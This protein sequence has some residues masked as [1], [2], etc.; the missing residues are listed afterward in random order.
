MRTPSRPRVTLDGNEAVASIAYQLSEIIAIYPI[1]PS[2]PMGELADQ[3]AAEGRPNIWG[4]VPTVIEMQSE[5]GAAGA[6]H[7]ALQAG[8]LATTF[9]SSQGL[10][11][12]IP[13]MYK[14]AGELTATVFHVAARSL[15]THALSIFGDHSD[16][17]AARATGFALLASGSVQEAMDLALIAH[18]ATLESRIPFLHFFDGFRTSHEVMKVEMLAP[19]DLRALIDDEL[20]RAHRARALSPDRPFIRGTAQNPDVYF[21]SREAVNPFYRACPMIVEQVM[22]RFARQVGR[23]YRLFDYVGAPDADRVLVL[24]GSGAEAAHETV[25]E[26]LAR[27]EAVGL[28]K[29]RLYRPFSVAHFIAAVPPTVR[30]LAVLD[31][32]KE[33]GSIG[34][35][36][37]LD[38]VAAVHE[39]M[40]DGMA[41]FTARPRI[42]GG[43][44][45]LSSKEFT[46]AMIKAIFDEMKREH[47]KNHFTIGIHD[48]VTHT[49]LTDDPT[50]STEDPQTVRAIFYGL[51]ADGTVSANRNSIKI[52]GELTDYYAQGYFVYDS[53]KAGSMTI[54]HLRF[55]PRPI[56]SSYLITRANF[57]ACH[58]F[59]FLERINVLKVAEPGATFLLNSPYGPEEVWDHLPRTIQREILEKNI[60]FFVVDAYRVAREVGLGGR[61]NTIMQACFFALITGDVPNA[62]SR[63][64]ERG[65]YLKGVL[66]F[67]HALAAMREAMW[68]TYG[69]R[70]A[71]IVEKNL[72]AVDRA[73]EN[74]YEVRV[75]GRVTSAFDLRPPV[76]P[77][78][79]AFVRE[80]TARMIAGEGDDLP[81]SA[82]PPDGTY[83]SGT[84][85][86]EKR[87]I[88]SEIPVWD[89][90]LCIQCGKCV[91]VCPHSV[92]RAK[93][94]DP[95]RLVEAPPTF[96][97]APARWVEFK[98]W[99]YTLQ[100]APED[101]TGC[102]LCVEV[103]PAKSKTE[104]R[105]KALT[106]RPQAPLRETERANWEF[107]LRL[108]D[109][110][111]H[112]L[113]IGQ[114]KDVQLLEPLFEF[115]GACAGC[116]ETPYIK[117]LT[118]LFGDRLLIANATGCSSIYGGN[119][120]TTPYT[121][122]REG[123]G[124]AWSNS[125]FE[126]NAEFGLGLRLALN[127]QA[128]YA[129]SLLRRLAAHLG[130]ELVDAV[131]TADQ[132]T[133][134]GIR[135]QRER[136]GVLK[137]R[138]RALS[139]PE[140]R[141]LLDVADA[142]VRKSVWIIGGDGWAYDI[143]SGGV[144]HVLASGHDVNILVLDTEVYSN[145]GGQ[146]SKATPRGAVAKFAAGGKPTPKKDLALMAMTYGTVY[147]ARIA[148]GANDTQTVKAFLEAEAY[149]GPSL[150]IAY[151]HCIAHGYDLRFGMEQQ[152]AAVLSG[153]WPLMRYHP[154]R[155]K[156]GKN[157]LILD[158]KTP[159]L[160]LRQYVYNETRYTML[161]HSRPE[162]ARALLELA[163]R[164][165]RARWRL[166]EYLANLPVEEWAKEARYA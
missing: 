14:I 10:L 113:H 139:L 85:Q 81:V 7:G 44:Y 124:P 148:M 120:P 48:D 98:R 66:S 64:E 141:Q 26:L 71:A 69:K 31:R 82:F 15:A 22:E 55:G 103:C 33:P 57:V 32:T 40:A 58:Q 62:V 162:A 61:I 52:I 23:G 165:V 122:N 38:V 95:T 50:F 93:V 154:D 156:E 119:L 37:Y 60:R 142:L 152:K 149:P 104:P 159:S 53:K 96:K 90:E 118:Q 97:S 17:M 146:M 131:L 46:P 109:V 73:M 129:R 163:E 28:I 20:V 126:D 147:V 117:L 18:A 2:S 54:S 49:S 121:V 27:G 6:L 16:V 30:A 9:T 145:T 100:V 153:Y 91:L 128:E 34:E 130:E 77:E 75:P 112:H 164:D 115:P 74:L 5:G 47:P 137:E 4:A 21:Q 110:E 155:L 11:L 106:L 127:H 45:G 78:A 92:I 35:P 160:P 72:A 136:I 19:E 56:R 68:K 86:W 105:R 67:E 116:G 87:N 111:R 59:P 150:I 151:S 80:V 114:V 3:W 102:A 88:A 43:R 101:C 125:L 84:A 99:R 70:G 36:L 8:A 135:R 166:Y 51:G 134:E 83:P 12:M 140:A 1:T 42:I 63:A 41:S 39:A 123:R 157:P 161:V 76:P 29:V 138:L 143:G 65:G 24:M 79:P 25:E 144:D 158:S 13:N 108:P 94:Y 107:F 133:E 89:E 132:S